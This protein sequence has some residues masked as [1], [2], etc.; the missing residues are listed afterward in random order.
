MED[1]EGTQKL[2]FKLSILYRYDIF[3]IQPDL[4]AQGVVMAFYLFIMDSLL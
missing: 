3:V 1:L 2:V 4:L